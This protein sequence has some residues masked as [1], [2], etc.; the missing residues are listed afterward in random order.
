MWDTA[1]GKPVQK[2]IETETES[3]QLEFTKDGS[4]LLQLANKELQLLDPKKE[5]KVVWKASEV[6]RF[7]FN[8]VLEKEE[9][10]VTTTDGSIAFLNLAD[11]MEQFRFPRSE[12][13]KTGNGNALTNLLY[14]PKGAYLVAGYFDGSISSILL[15][16]KTWTERAC[17]IANRPLTPQ[18]QTLYK[19]SDDQV[20]SIKHWIW[21][22]PSVCSPGTS[23]SH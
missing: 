14:G 5:R 22:Q 13:D 23:D 1:T 17:R 2:N 12:V 20:F 4:K 19:L 16:S 15:D 9:V 6:S 21:P 11:G 7:V 10:V 8:P 18:E 3:L